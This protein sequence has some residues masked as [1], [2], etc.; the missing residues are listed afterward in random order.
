MFS[1][2]HVLLACNTAQVQKA[3]GINTALCYRYPAIM[4]QGFLSIYEVSKLAQILS[5]NKGILNTAYQTEVLSLLLNS[6]W[7][8]AYFVQ[9]YA[10]INITFFWAKLFQLGHHR[11][12][13]DSL[14]M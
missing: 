9:L 12:H 14:S 8:A 10:D 2:V 1:A 7:D 6:K 11:H 4:R 13:M 3:R 5:V